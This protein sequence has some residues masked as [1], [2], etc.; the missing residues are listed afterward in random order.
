VPDD[1]SGRSD[2]DIAIKAVGLTK[3]FAAGKD[4]PVTV[5][6]GISF[7]VPRGAIVSFLGHNGAGKTTLIRILSTLLSF[8]AGSVSVFGD[9]LARDPR[10]IRDR[11]AT[12]GQFAAVD[13]NLTGRE[14]LEFF[15]RLRRLG[16]RAA[17]ERATELLA[18]FGLDD[19]ADRHVK[20]YSGGMRRRIDIAISLMVVPDLLFLDEPTTGLDPVSRE[21]L[22]ALVRRL[23]DD[24]MTLVLTTQYLEEAQALADLVYLLKDGSIVDAGTPGEI[25]GRLGTHVLVAAFESDSDA[26]HFGSHLSRAGVVGAGVRTE[27]R[28]V[29]CDVAPGAAAITEISHV[30]AVSGIAPESLSISPP[31]LNEVFIRVNTADAAATGTGRSGSGR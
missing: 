5:L 11:I 27:G 26:K 10:A 24:G 19:A 7:E 21:D 14:N 17:A 12:T 16:R 6:D 22:W 28:T 15:G 1:I 2:S 18:V 8:D 4:S 30:V 29:T 25:R 3:S 13:E 31:T 23:R 9:D 20:E